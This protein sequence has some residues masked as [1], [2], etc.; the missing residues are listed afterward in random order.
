MAILNFFPTGGGAGKDISGAT[1]TLGAALSYTG[2]LQTQ[3]V[4]SVALNGATLTPNTDYVVIGNTGTAVGSY[5]LTVL[6]INK[7]SGF[8]AAAWSISK[9]SVTK[10]T[11]SGT[12]FTYDGS[13]HGPTVTGFDSTWM[14]KSGDESA[15]NAGSYSLTVALADVDNTKWSDDSTSAIVTAWSIAKA[16]GS[17]SASPSS[18]SISGTAGATAT[19][20]IARAGDGAISAASSDTSVATVSVSGDT[21]T[22]TAVDD[23]T[24]TITVSVDEGTNHLSASCT[25]GVTVALTHVYGASWDGTSTTAWTRTDDAAG[26]TDPV[27]YVSGATAY[28]SPFDNRMPWSGMTVVDDAEAGK[29]VQIPKFWYK[30]TQNGA[31]MKIQIANAP[32]DGFSVSPAHMDRGDGKGERDVV[33]IARYHCAS[34]Y[35]SKT[36]VTP[37]ASKTRSAFR[38]SIHALGSTI[39][40]VD[41]AM[42]FTI[43]LLYLVE[44][45]NWNSQAKIGYGC[46]NNS[47]T[48]NMGA[49]DSMPYHTGTMQTSRTTYGVGVQ[50]RNIE[51][52]WDN[53]YDWIDGCYNSS[54][55]LMLIKNPSSFSDSSGGTSM[56]TPSSGYPSAFSVKNVSGFFPLFLPS[57]A[58]GSDSTYSCDG[59]YFDS[60]YPCVCAG[61]YCYRH[62]DLGLFCWYYYSASGTRGSLGSRSMK[63]P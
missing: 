40:Q 14:S 36:G 51:G 32:V 11:I 52:L 42:R 26:F 9:K 20:T 50:Y 39:W 21:V 1:V 47:G 6:G 49:S 10:P 57:A 12:S 48:Q 4:A 18:L 46:G 31:G 61:G 3:T 24:A 5:S 13:S 7:Y 62:L 19:A 37:A 60:S 34:D 63:L 8:V 38:S 33:Y 59:W 29:M 25:I 41:W 43:F 35:K 28:S 56:G 54:S 53:V 2:A 27:P 55:G 23:G 16:T 44:F 22:V 15:T 17:A 45:A 58:N 30:L